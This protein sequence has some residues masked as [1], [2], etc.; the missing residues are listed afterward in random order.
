MINSIAII[1][2]SVNWNKANFT[3]SKFGRCDLIKFFSVVKECFACILYTQVRMHNEL[4]CFLVVLA[5][6]NAT[7]T[8]LL[9]WYDKIYNQSLSLDVNQVLM[10][11]TIS[12]SGVYRYM[13]SVTYF[14]LIVVIMKSYFS[15]F[16]RFFTELFVLLMDGIFLLYSTWYYL[17][18][19]KVNLSIL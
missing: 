2:P 12:Y 10:W 5:L 15:M 13:F 19:Q 16:P 6:L 18:N 11:D 8:I 14:S 4:L 3:A 1:P 7:G 17:F 9:L